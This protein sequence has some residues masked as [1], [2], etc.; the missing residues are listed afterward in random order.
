MAELPPHIASMLS[1]SNLPDD[2]EFDDF[3]DQVK[4][5]CHYRLCALHATALAMRLT[6]ASGERG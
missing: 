6:H 4:R 3:M 5:S 2:D 1:R